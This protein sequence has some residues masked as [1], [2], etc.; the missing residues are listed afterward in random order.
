MAK[1]KKAITE[2]ELKKQ[3]ADK[4]Q[5]R[6]QVCGEKLLPILEQDKCQLVVRVRV[7]DQLIPIGA[8]LNLPVTIH[9]ESKE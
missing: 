9:V 5:E 1:E 7:G 6:A 8:I 4:A 2:D 3:M